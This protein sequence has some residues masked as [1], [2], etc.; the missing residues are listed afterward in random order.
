MIHIGTSGFSYDDWVGRFYPEKTARNAMLPYYASAF[1]CVEINST[2]YAI[3]GAASF[4]SM[5][6]RTPDDFTFVVK[7]HKD[8]TH[9]DEP[10][11]ASFD[12]FVEAIGPLV[13]SRK[14]GCLLAQYPWGFKRTPTSESRLADLRQRVGDIPTVVEF[15]NAE[16]AV[17]ETYELLH[18]L[19]LGFCCV[20][21]PSLKDLMPRESVRTSDTGYVRFH[22]RNA[23]KW[24]KHEQAYERYDYLYTQEELEE[25]IPRVRAIESGAKDTYLFFNNHYQGKSVENA[26]MFA[27]MLGLPLLRETPSSIPTQ[28][29]LETD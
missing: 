29:S 23:R 28:L 8:M 3:P 24:W 11:E 9:A 21:E 12:A 25:W 17:G 4:E 14:L 22:G 20:D 10:V 26:R 6:R 2:Y 16:W 7:A 19:G 15:R 18:G 27:R 5:V 13:E 1:G